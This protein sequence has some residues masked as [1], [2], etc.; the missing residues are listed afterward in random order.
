MLRHIWERRVHT[1]DRAGR[2]FLAPAFLLA[3]AVCATRFVAVPAMARKCRSTV[4]DFSQAS[5]SATA[6]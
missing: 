3:Y 5:I 6:V 2:Y 1:P 4:L